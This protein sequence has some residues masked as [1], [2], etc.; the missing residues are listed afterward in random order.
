MSDSLP[1]P[2]RVAVPIVQGQSFSDALNR[3]DAPGYLGSMDVV[4]GLLRSLAGEVA[5]RVRRVADG[6]L[7]QEAAIAADV[8]AADGLA[9]ILR[10]GS[11]AYPGTAIHAAGPMD[12]HVRANLPGLEDPPVTEAVAS[13]IMEVYLAVDTAAEDGEEAMQERMGDALVRYARL[14]SGLPMSVGGEA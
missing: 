9:M 14:F 4:D 2:D 6:S 13:F 5:D 12:D 10:G 1:Q 11:A 7:E 3:A 8:L